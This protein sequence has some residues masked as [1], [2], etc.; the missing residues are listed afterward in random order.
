MEHEKGARSLHLFRPFYR[1]DEVL[2]EIRKCLEAGWTGLG[3]KT[4]EFE[5]KWKDYT[6]FSNAH[7][8]N[9]ATGG[10]HLALAILKQRHGWSDGDE[11]ITTPITFVSTNHAIL[12]ERLRPVF[13]DVDEYLCIDPRSVKDRISERTKGII[14]V[15]VGG[16]SGRYEEIVQIA[17]DRGLALILDAAHMAGTR[18]RG[19]IVGKE[20]DAIVYS[21][22]SVKNLPTAD[23]GMICFKDDEND[24]TARKLTWLGISKDTYTRTHEQAAYR[25]LYDVEQTGFKYHGN[26]IMAAIALVQL[27]YLDADNAYRRQIAGWYDGKFGP[28]GKISPVPL[29]ENCESSRHLYQVEVERRDGLILALNRMSIFPGVHYRCN[30]EYR[31]YRYAR[32]SCP[33]A[34]E[35]AARIVS[36]PIHLGLTKQ[37]IDYISENVTKYA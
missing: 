13:A 32:G 35:K 24:E 2:S 19:E 23:S 7:F 31:M 8:L 28:E 20:A 27:R 14:F 9:S 26:S 37:D 36:L 25:W 11:I 34:E 22:H 17:R 16:S 10:L 15:G 29:P 6:G 30:T 33:I 3:F 12:Y 5:A 1:V 4:V 18:L 21:F